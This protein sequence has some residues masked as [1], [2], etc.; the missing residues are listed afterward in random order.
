MGTRFSSTR[1]LVRDR[2]CGTLWCPSFPNRGQRQTT[3]LPPVH[4]SFDSNGKRDFG[5]LQSTGEAAMGVLSEVE[6]V[7]S[8]AAHPL[9]FEEITKRV[10]QRD[11]WKTNG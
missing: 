9:H 7:L 4:S 8:A 6:A 11:I 1:T 10:L 3:T 2:D 5:A